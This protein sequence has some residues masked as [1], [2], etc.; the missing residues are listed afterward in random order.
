MSRPGAQPKPARR[1]G[2]ART[3]SPYVRRAVG[4]G[5]SVAKPCLTCGKYLLPLVLLMVLASSIFYVRIL[6]GPISL[7]VLAKPIARSIAA[8]MPGFGVSIEDALVRL[9]E[10]GEVEFRLRN[11]HLLDEQGS[12]VAVA[13]LAAI[14]LSMDGLMSARL[15]PEK[16]VLIEPR[17]LLTYSADRGL[18]FSFTRP[19][20]ADQAAVPT[21]SSR[22]EATSEPGAAPDGSAGPGLPV[23]LRQLD[24]ARVIA[25]A[26]ARARQRSD[27]ASFLRQFGMR[28][29]TLIFDYAGDQTVWRVPQAD[30]ALSHKTR[31]SVIEG[32]VTV[33]SERGPWTLAFWSEASGATEQVNLKA[34][35]RDLV[36]SAVAGML[37]NLTPLRAVDVPASGDVMLQLTSGGELMGGT[38]SLDLSRGDLRLPWLEG[39]PLTIEGGSLDLRYDPGGRALLI[40]PSTLVWGQSRLTIAG[41]VVSTLGPDGR[42][43]WAYRLNGVEGRLASEEFNVAPVPIQ[44][45]LAEGLFQ[46]ET[47]DLT[48]EQK[49]VAGGGEL[50]VSGKIGGNQADTRINLEGQIGNIPLAILQGLWP[51]ALGA[52]ARHWV[53]ESLL[54]GQVLGGTFK[55]DSGSDAG[56]G[57]E[58]QQ[59]SL[60][61]QAADLLVRPAPGL[62][63]VEIPRALVQLEGP[64]LEITVPESTILLSDGHKIALKAG[65]FTVGDVLS[66]HPAGE[67]AFSGEGSAP[68]VLGLVEH[69]AFGIGRLSNIRSQNVEG[70]VEASL[71]IALPLRRDITFGDVRLEGSGRLSDGRASKLIGS[72]DA[73]A[74]TV[75]FEITDKAINARGD[76]LLSGV[77]VKLA[78][79]HI[80]DALPEKQPPLRLTATLDGSDRTQLGIDANHLVHGEVPVEVTITRS[81]DEE[82]RVHVWAD[83][84]RA[85]MVLD[86]V[87]WRKPPGRT[88]IMQFDLRPGVRYETEL[89]NFQIVGDDIAISGWMGL[90]SNE[91]L[92]EFQF[93]EFSVNVISRLEVRGTLRQDHV[94]DVVAEGQTYD[95][96]DAFRSLFSVGE[97]GDQPLPKRPNAPGLDLKAEIA[98]VIGFSDEALRGF[99]MRLSRRGDKLT[100]LKARGMLDGKKPLEVELQHTANQPRRLV[101]VTEDAGQAFRLV[102]FYPSLVGGRMRLDVNLDARGAAEKTGLLR[103]ERFRILGDPVV[104]EVLQVPDET[105][106]YEQR[107]QR[108][109]R[110]AIDFDWMRVPFSVGHGQFVMGDSEIRGPLV[111]VTMRGKADFRSRQVNIGGTYVPLQGLN[112]AIGFIPGLGQLL[113]GP[114]GEGVLGITFAIQGAMNEPQV[115]VNPLSLVA[116]GIFREM[117]QMTPSQSVTPPRAPQQPSTGKGARSSS[118]PAAPAPQRR[119]GAAEPEVLS[120]WSSETS[121]GPP[122]KKN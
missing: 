117:F 17:L 37:P 107:R 119:G 48:I 65:R 84:T 79:Q 13:P 54:G 8:E 63:L 95:G 106:P 97:L 1:R 20:D 2:Q 81:A 12:P 60:A 35:I 76:M 121:T 98:T 30:V 105:R 101:A 88:A 49:L 99:T 75:A 42:E 83:M 11:V 39:L 18:S 51:R 36:P 10:E 24:L 122:L 71:T 6:Y 87:A 74:S 34:S 26:S 14:E 25:E 69:E 82:H 102:D 66:E 78:W 28:N 53:G 68:A 116:P 31:R 43:I 109:V 58:P 33:A 100:A 4:I 7:K 15:S 64:A 22:A 93:P 9:N 91:R 120:G 89:H 112:S 23:A 108:V 92:K 103:V 56:S 27:A 29:A 45:W 73:Q 46:P 38:F 44:S 57:S 85:D 19:P 86:N 61:I 96:R 80:F 113:A 50:L 104:A 110:Q 118:A 67:I 90:D 3:P 32:S 16:V 41:N 52:D 94:W 72:H 59:L 21:D 55:F 40:E 111:G 5:R 114:R 115:L 47:G 62:P 77:P 70:N